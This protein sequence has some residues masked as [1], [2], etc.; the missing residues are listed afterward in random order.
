MGICW[1]ASAGGVVAS[2]GVCCAVE[3]V[4]VCSETA[5]VACDVGFDEEALQRVN[6]KEKPIAARNNKAEKCRRMVIMFD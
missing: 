5:V 4:V 3:E 1:S 2:A 6:K